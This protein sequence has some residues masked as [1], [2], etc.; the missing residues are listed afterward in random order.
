MRGLHILNEGDKQ[1]EHKYFG[2]VCKKVSSQYVEQQYL[3]RTPVPDSDIVELR[4]GRRAH[5]EVSPA[6][7]MKFVCKVGYKGEVEPHEWG[8][9]HNPPEEEDSD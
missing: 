8:P 2:D 6:D 4:W 5:Y 3:V 7:I 9:N 1:A